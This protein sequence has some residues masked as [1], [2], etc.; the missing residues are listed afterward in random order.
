[1][2]L[3]CLLSFEVLCV[4][5]T[6]EWRLSYVN[7]EFAICP[8]YPPAVIVPK[9]IDDD[10][11]RK[12]AAFRHGGRFPVLSYYHKKNGMV[13]VRGAALLIGLAWVGGFLCSGVFPFLCAFW[14]TSLAKSF[15]L[16]H[17]LC[18]LQGT[19]SGMLFWGGCTEFF[20]NCSAFEKFGLSSEHSVKETVYLML[21]AMLFKT[22]EWHFSS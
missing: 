10:A 4:F 15:P 1:M 2:T 7:K 6:S 5:Q 3:T 22:E 19:R 16:V 8:S 20:Q 13:S 11:L 18:K 21:A 14:L 12:V 9:S 17:P